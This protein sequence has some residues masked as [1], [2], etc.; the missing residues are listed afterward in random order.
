MAKINLLALCLLPKIWVAAQS[1]SL[2][3]AKTAVQSTSTKDA[4]PTI[5]PFVIPAGV[6]SG[7][8]LPLAIPAAEPNGGRPGMGKGKMGGMGG[9]G[10]FG[11][12]APR[13]PSMGRRPPPEEIGPFGMQGGL[14]YELCMPP[15][16]IC[17]GLRDR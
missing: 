16:L 10:G 15:S 11:A 4:L 14:P 6:L 12:A 2:A 3:S 8:G 9:K 13:A 1:P 17:S 7:L 5:T